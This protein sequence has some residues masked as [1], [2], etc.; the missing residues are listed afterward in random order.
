MKSLIEAFESS[1]FKYETGFSMNRYTS[2]KVGGSA[3]V[4]VYPR[5]SSE[6]IDI[7]NLLRSHEVKWM[8]LGSG[9]NVIAGDKIN[10]VVVSTKNMKRVDILDGGRVEAESGATLGQVLNLTLKAGLLGLEFATGIPG[11]IGGGVIMNAGA[12]GG[13]L[14]DVVERVWVWHEGKEIPINKDEIG[15]E[16]RG[17]HFPTGSVVTR[18]RLALK[19]GDT[20]LSKE[21]VKLYLKKRNKTQPVEIANSGSVFKNPKEMPAGKLLDDLGLKG[22]RIGTAKFSERHAN[23]IVNMGGAKPGDVLKLIDFA[24]NTV[25]KKT[26]I[27]LENE[28]KIIGEFEQ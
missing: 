8:V 20:S 22:Y 25:Y 27:V 5:N 17:S 21:A 24:K 11:T 18:I 4:I 12:N 23:F 26:G 9:S 3:E 19:P 1:G 14:C 15:F 13:E 16:Y 7:L 6:L 28:V 10:G 2:M